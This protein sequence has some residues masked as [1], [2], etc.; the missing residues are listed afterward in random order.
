MRYRIDRLVAYLRDLFSNL[1]RR[2]VLTVQYHGWRELFVRSAT[3]PLRLTPWGAHMA[4]GRA[5]KWAIARQWY[6]RKGR[7]VAVVIPHYGEPTL[8]IQAVES[9]KA[10]TKSG[11][12]RIIVSDDASAPEHVA[13][14]REVDGIELVVSEQNTGFAANCNRGFARASDSDIVLLNNDVIAMPGWLEQLQ[15]AA[16]SGTDIGIAGPKLLYADGTIQSAGTHRNLGAPEWFDHL[17]RFRPSDYGPANIGGD[18]LA[19]TGAAMY[20]KRSTLDTIGDFD[21]RYGMAYEDVDLCLRAWDAGLRVWCAPASEL[22]HLESK[23]RPVDPGQREL[24]SQ[25]YFWE[26]WGDWLDKRDVRTDSGALR[27][28]YVTEDTGVG[29]GHRVVFEHLNGLKARGHEAELWSLDKLGPPDWYDL[30]VPIRLFETYR[31]LSAALAD[32]DAIKVATWWNTARPVWRASVK[33]GIPV[34]FVQDIE[35]S[36]YPGQPEPQNHVLASYRHEFRYLTTSQWVRDK[37][38]ELHVDPVPVPPGID[39]TRWHPLDGVEREDDVLLAVGRTNPLKNF[40]LTADAYA[41]LPEAER[42]R[43]WLFGVEPEV[44]RDLGATYFEK[45]SDAEVN[46]LYNKATALIQTSHHEGFCLP[47]L[48]AMAA[49][50]PVI[51]TD[52][53]GNRDFIEDGVNCLLVEDDPESVAAAIERLFGDPD[54]RAR[55]A[56]G[57]RRTAARYELQGQLDKVERFF[58]DV[59]PRVA[60]SDRRPDAAP[61]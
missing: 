36:Y 10:T 51:C 6:R 38:R 53:D 19:M 40:P 18:M 44:G 28:I 59:A 16:Y 49:G 20:L 55:L 50:L 45:P 54:L 57:G 21:E 61:A 39:S 52:S 32:V 41:S 14:L 56:D 7:D 33:R 48:E 35:T 12:V 30:D 1:P 17:Y 2:V 13:V 3:F 60:T 47:L 11:R 58:Q 27:V 4:A 25:R 37:L 5:T 22:T 43:L 8:T 9:I 31:E 29:G 46:E 23:T 34:Y 24:D 42:P 26:K 15:Y